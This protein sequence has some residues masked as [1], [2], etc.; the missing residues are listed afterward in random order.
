MNKGLR[1]M[2]A[3]EWNPNENYFLGSV[4]AEKPRLAHPCIEKLREGPVF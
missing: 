4:T 3:M 1:Q 2:E